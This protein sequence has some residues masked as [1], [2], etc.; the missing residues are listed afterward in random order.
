MSEVRI[1]LRILLSS[2]KNGVNVP[3][4]SNKQKNLEKNSFLLASWRSR[5]TIAGS[6]AGSRSIGQRHG[7]RIHNTGYYRSSS[8]T[9]PHYMS[10]TLKK[11][12][13]ARFRTLTF[14]ANL[15]TIMKIIAMKTI[16]LR[17][18]SWI[19]FYSNWQSTYGNKKRVELPL[20][21]ASKTD[22]DRR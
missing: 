9:K 8:C 22:H 20:R 1:R 21:G 18:R 15:F 14:A 3:S 16:S 5:T 12:F 4:K 13:N 6:G 17:T 19:Q 10:S 7:S 2:S 11:S